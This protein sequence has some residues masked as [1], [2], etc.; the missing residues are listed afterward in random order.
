LAIYLATNNDQ[1]FGE[2]MPHGRYYNPRAA[3]EYQEK[4]IANLRIL[5]GHIADTKPHV[6]LYAFNE[7]K[8]LFQGPRESARFA[9]EIMDELCQRSWNAGAARKMLDHAAS[10]VMEESIG[11]LDRDSAPVVMWQTATGASDGEIRTIARQ[12]LVK[13]VERAL[14]EYIRALRL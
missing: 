7:L 8:S 4:E 12:D 6:R 10:F 2:Y 9:P 13:T 1:Y 5:V 14:P 3:R 11:K